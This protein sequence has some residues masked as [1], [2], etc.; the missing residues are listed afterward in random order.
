MKI[1]QGT[2]FCLVIYCCKFTRLYCVYTG[3]TSRP[4]LCCH[5][6]EPPEAGQAEAQCS[7]YMKELQQFILRAQNFYLKDFE[8]M[9]FIMDRLVNLK[10]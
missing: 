10:F 8:C 2:A 5:S 7:L 1:S 6:N 9:D 4:F 3:K